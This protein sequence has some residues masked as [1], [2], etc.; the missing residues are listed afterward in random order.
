MRAKPF[1]RTRDAAL[2]QCGMSVGTHGEP[3][4]GR[5]E[6]QLDALGGQVLPDRPRADR[7]T[8]G[9]DTADGLDAEQRDRAMRAAV[10]GR[11]LVAVA[12]ETELRD[13]RFGHRFA[14][15][16]GP[17][18]VDLQDAHRLAHRPEG[19]DRH[20]RRAMRRAS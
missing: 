12:L 9:R 10:D 1:N 3:G 16:P 15:H 6:R 20:P 19:T 17:R 11:R 14:R 5:Q 18:D 13:P 4:A 2:L 8:L 7:M